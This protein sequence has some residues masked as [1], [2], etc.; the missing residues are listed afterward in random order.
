[1]TFVAK[2]DYIVK[3]LACGKKTLCGIASHYDDR[4]P[5]ELDNLIN[6]VEFDR[7]MFRVN[8]TIQR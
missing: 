4:Y 8:D 2:D 6:K 1:M 3:Q 7:I 5:K